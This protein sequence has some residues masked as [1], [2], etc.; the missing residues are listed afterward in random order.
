MSKTNIGHVIVHELIKENNKDF[1]YSKPYH[2]RESELDKENQTVNKL[3][4][5]VIELYGS[6]GNSAHYG[7]FK[8]E[9]NERGPIPDE[10]HKYFSLSKSN[11]DNFISLSKLIMKQMFHSAKGQPWASGGYIVFTDYISQ[12]VRFLL[13]TM[14]KKKD[15]VRI[16][17]NLEPEEMI[18]LDLSNINQAAKINFHL[19]DKYLNANELEK[20]ELSFLSFVSKNTGQSAAAYF[21]SALGCDKGIASAGATRKLPKEVRNFFKKQ[22]DLKIF[23]ESFKKEVVKYLDLKLQNKESAK[24]SDIEALALTHLNHLDE[25]TRNNHITELMRYLNSENIRIPTEFVVNKATLEKIKNVIYKDKLMSFNFDKELLGVTN[26]ARV[27][28]DELNS[29]LCFNKLPEEALSK[30]RAA[31]K[32]KQQ[33]KTDG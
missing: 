6:R 5:D 10:F 32:E 33:E 3:V 8:S 26:D 1:D 12:G 29:S 21:I 20:T 15:G 16:S 2:L 31:I 23:A 14:I 18:H 28:F 27:F 4:E 22:P 7:V 11:S 9:K 19:Y 13:V 30:I 25:S 24:L 17:Q